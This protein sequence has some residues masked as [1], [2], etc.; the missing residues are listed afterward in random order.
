MLSKVDWEKLI[1]EANAR[2]TPEDWKRQ[3]ISFAYGNGVLSN[4]EIT[5][6]SV[7]RAAI[8]LA[9]GGDDD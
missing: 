5:R 9:E 6:E 2:M 7:E 3:R 4:P 1:A 8:A